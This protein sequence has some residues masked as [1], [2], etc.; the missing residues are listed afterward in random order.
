MTSH[1]RKFLLTGHVV[2][3][4]GWLGAIGAYL[5]MAIAG[6]TG[7]DVQTVRA[8]YLSMEVVARVVIIPCA[9][10]S[11]LTGIAQSLGSPWGLFRHY[12]VLTKLLLTIGALVVLIF[13]FAAVERMAHVAREEA[14]APGQL[15]AERVQLVVHAV[16]GM[17]VVL[18]ALALS[19]YKPWGLTSYGKHRQHVS[20]GSI[21]P[22]ARARVAPEVTMP[23]RTPR[24]ALVIGFHAVGLFVLALVV[25]VLGGGFR[26]H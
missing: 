14:L 6:L 4:V 10:A 1:L 8:S 16:G 25:H 11:V 9:L 23:P 20:G 5:A 15:T 13:H 24:W 12:W 21:P 7:H 2:V 18:L 26:G 22:P 19:I 3:S 17:C